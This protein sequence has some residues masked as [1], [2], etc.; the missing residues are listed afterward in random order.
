MK[1]LKFLIKPA[2]FIVSL[3]GCTWMTLEI[4]KISPSDAGKTFLP[5][6]DSANTKPEFVSSPSDIRY[7]LDSKE[8]LRNLS[9][10]YKSGLIDS[11]ELDAS[12]DQFIIGME[13]YHLK[14]PIQILK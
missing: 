1:R 5:Q 10:E 3:V 9:V 8:H 2:F 11:A 7:L 14:T 4:E 12:L 13:N 6:S